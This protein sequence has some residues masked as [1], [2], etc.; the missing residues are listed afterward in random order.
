MISFVETKSGLLGS[1][2]SSGV[3]SAR[4]SKGLKFEFKRHLRVG[5]VK[6]LVDSKT[7]SLFVRFL[8]GD[9]ILETLDLVDELVWL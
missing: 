5:N 1:D 4:T 6:K 2:E 7:E 8:L 3:L 9:R